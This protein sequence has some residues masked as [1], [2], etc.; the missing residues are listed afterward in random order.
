M[1][2]LLLF[3]TINTIHAADGIMCAM[4]AMNFYPEQKEISLNTMFIIEG[5]A[6]SQETINSFKNR[7]IFLESEN[8]DLIQLHLQKILKGQMR[9]TQAILKPTIPLKPY[10]T[11][12]LKYANQTKE[13]SKEM[14][15][16]KPSF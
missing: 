8:G 5:Y 9:L 15:R 13:E 1:S 2:L 10:T 4:S 14:T 16:Y 3:C 11:Y 6:I 7:K 12:S